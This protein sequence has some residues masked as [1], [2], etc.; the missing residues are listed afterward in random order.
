MVWIEIGTQMLQRI[1]QS[2]FI[3]SFAQ[4][5]R[6]RPQ[7]T[8]AALRRATLLFGGLTLAVYLG[9]TLIGGLL[10]DLLYPEVYA[11]AK[12][13]IPLLAFRL[14]LM[15]FFPMRQV[16]VALGDSRYVALVQSL[17]GI[18]AAA[19]VYFAFEPFGLDGAILAFA[20]APLLSCLLVLAYPGMMRRAGPWPLVGALA[21]P[22]FVWA[23]MQI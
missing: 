12:A 3:P 7:R 8:D 6:E 23:V 20:V 10:I 21:Y 13:F 1:G 19:A 5:M 2:I 17:A 15:G 14:L 11:P 9:M 22:V 18:S 4:I 16:I